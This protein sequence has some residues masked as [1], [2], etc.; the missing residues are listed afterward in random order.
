MTFPALPAIRNS[1]N[2]FQLFIRSH[3]QDQLEIWLVELGWWQDR[4]GVQDRWAVEDD[5][6]DWIQWQW[7]ELIVGLNLQ[8]RLRA[9][10][11]PSARFGVPCRVTSFPLPWIDPS[12]NQILG[13]E[14]R[15]TAQR[16]AHR[17]TASVIFFDLVKKKKRS[18]F[19]IVLFS[20]RLSVYHD[21]YCWHY[22]AFW[23]DLCQEPLMSLGPAKR[24]WLGI[25]LN[26]ENPSL[27]AM[28][29]LREI[30]KHLLKEFPPQRILY[31]LRLCKKD[32][33]SGSHFK[34]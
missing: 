31:I 30:L 28:I 21:Y 15:D 18:W 6:N 9:S 32:P 23:E 2:K 11:P 13:Q 1:M 29:E 33:D 12:Q 14:C 17:R 8:D 34:K 10:Q 19:R 5:F 27:L 3:W 7:I 26:I 4:W 24:S 20:A 16:N 25:A 22:W